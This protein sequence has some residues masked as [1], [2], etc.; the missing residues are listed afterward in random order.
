MNGTYLTQNTFS[1]ANTYTKHKHK[2]R[3]P[4]HNKPRLIC[5]NQV[6]KEPPQITPQ[7]DRQTKVGGTPSS[8]HNMFRRYKNGVSKDRG[9]EAPPDLYPWVGRPR[10][11]RTYFANNTERGKQPCERNTQYDAQKRSQT[12]CLK[13]QKQSVPRTQHYSAFV[14]RVRPHER[15]LKRPGAR[16]APRSISLGGTP[17]SL[18]SKFR[19][20]HRAWQTTPRTK[21]NLRCARTI[22]NCMQNIDSKQKSD[23]Q[24]IFKR[25]RRT[26]DARKPPHIT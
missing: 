23:E 5:K 11:Y 13:H 2:P 15:S 25:K 21:H 22:A 4:Q 24:S 26:T 18:Q 12:I 17:Q 3:Q 6:A 8:L 10:A 19:R 16:S 20:Y 9:R 1:I 7:N 14:V